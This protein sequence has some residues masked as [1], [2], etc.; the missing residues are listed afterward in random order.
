MKN[1]K[2]DTSNYI[3]IYIVPVE[4]GG[5][6]TGVYEQ[7]AG[8]PAIYGTDEEAAKARFELH[9]FAENCGIDISSW[10]MKRA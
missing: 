2:I 10:I 7:S 6:K 8:V 4:N 9:R 3:I 1:I 5:T